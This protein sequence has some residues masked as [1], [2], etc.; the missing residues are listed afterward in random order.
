VQEY[1]DPV[2][3]AALAPGVPPPSPIPAGAV[4]D[5]GERWDYYSQ[6]YAVRQRAR[7]NAA[8]ATNLGLIASWLILVPCLFVIAGGAV[9]LIASSVSAPLKNAGDLLLIYSAMAMQGVTVLTLAFFLIARVASLTRLFPYYYYRS[10]QQLWHENLAWSY[11]NEDLHQRLMQ[12]Q[13]QLSMWGSAKFTYRRLDH[14]LSFCACHIES[15]AAAARNPEQ[16]NRW[17]LRHENQ[18]AQMQTLF[19]QQNWVY[20]LCFFLIGS[21]GSLL[22]LLVMIFAPRYIIS[23][24][25]LIAFLDF[26]LEEPRI[27]VAKLPPPEE[28]KGWWARQLAPWRQRVEGRFGP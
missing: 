4:N 27:D 11:T 26:Y 24:A 22:M 1:P 7:E 21:L 13:S 14:Y 9:A 15:L 19:T 20:I 28:P 8:R 17:K 6:L 23:R 10:W 5:T 18:L 2:Q 3:Q 16:V 12:A 25:Y